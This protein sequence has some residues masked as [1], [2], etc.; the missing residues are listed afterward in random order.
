[1]LS[2]RNPLDYRFSLLMELE[3]DYVIRRESNTRGLMGNAVQL[4]DRHQV[5]E[6]YKEM[7]YQEGQDE[8]CVS[9]SAVK[10]SSA[11]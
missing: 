5:K 4:K 7:G 6:L 9:S 10:D 8:E 1:M 3:T 11:G 2:Q